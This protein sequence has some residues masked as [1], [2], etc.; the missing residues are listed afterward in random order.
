MEFFFNK[1]RLPIGVSHAHDRNGEATT[2]G[3]PLAMAM[4]IYH[5]YNSSDNEVGR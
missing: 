2:Q 5:Q 4:Y 3:D 1:P